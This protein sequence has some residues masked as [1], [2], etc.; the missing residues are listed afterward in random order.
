MSR[1]AQAVLL[2]PGY[3]YL[4]PWLAGAPETYIPLADTVVPTDAPG[5]NFADIGYSEEGWNLVATNEFSDWT[6]A[7]LVDPI[8]QV[9]LDMAFV[10]TPEP[11]TLSWLVLGGLLVTRRRR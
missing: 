1:D 7:E 6:P 5:G 10:I 8:T 3:L 2:G 4:A 11:A 9:S